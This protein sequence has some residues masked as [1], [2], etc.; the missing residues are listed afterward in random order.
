MIRYSLSSEN[1][2][3]ISNSLCSIN[4]VYSINHS[5]IKVTIDKFN[6]LYDWNG[7]FNM[8]EVDNR[9][10]KGHRFFIF[11]FKT[12]VVGHC[13]IEHKPDY[14]YS[15]NI[16]IDKTVHDKSIVDSTVYFVMLSD[17][18]FNE[19]VQSI[20]V[21]VDEWHK[22]SQDFCKRVGFHVN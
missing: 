21:D 19:G 18:L 1:L 5:D 9:I 2:N 14:T 6:S 20:H 13:W 22:K 12:K 17:K 15:Y 7:M 11:Y 16:F 8:K 4:E 10:S 3:R